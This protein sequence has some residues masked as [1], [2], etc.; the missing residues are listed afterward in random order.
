MLL[1]L[2]KQGLKCDGKYIWW[3]KYV[4]RD[5]TLYTMNVESKWSFSG[6]G[7]RREYPLQ[8]WKSYESI[9]FVLYENSVYLRG[10]LWNIRARVNRSGMLACYVAYRNPAFLREHFD[11][12]HFCLRLFVCWL[13]YPSPFFRTEARQIYS[14]TEYSTSGTS[15]SE[16][17][18]WIFMPRE[19]FVP[20]QSSAYN[21]LFR[22]E[23][24]A[25]SHAQHYITDKFWESVGPDINV[26]SNIN[27]R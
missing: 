14:R 17:V 23:I 18:F 20:S 24:E 21:F 15:F 12:L 10:Y 16:L 8:L 4:S 6:C 25:L 22:Q 27:L 26:V 7:K 2:F 11:E 1:G 19:Y 3:E 13:L 9:I 5:I